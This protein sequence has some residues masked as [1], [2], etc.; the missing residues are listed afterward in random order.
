MLESPYPRS[1]SCGRRQICRVSACSKNSAASTTNSPKARNRPMRCESESVDAVKDTRPLASEKA[2]NCSRKCRPSQRACEPTLGVKQL[3]STFAHR[4]HAASTTGIRAI[5]VSTPLIG[6]R[7][8]PR[9]R[10][11]ADGSTRYIGRLIF[12]AVRSGIWIPDAFGL[13][14]RPKYRNHFSRVR[15]SSLYYQTVGPTL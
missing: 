7:G 6:C 15:Y 9:T 11:H 13:K 1:S 14:T 5:A 12:G 8:S 10:T 2:R 3:A 4:P